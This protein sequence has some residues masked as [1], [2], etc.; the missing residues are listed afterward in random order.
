MGDVFALRDHC[1]ISSSTE[2]DSFVG[3][4]SDGSNLSI[5]FPLGYT[6]PARESTLRRDILNLILC[7][8]KFSGAYEATMGFQHIR[9]HDTVDFPIQAYMNILSVYRN[10]TSNLY[11]ER[12]VRYQRGKTTGKVNWS[13]TIKNET[14]IWSNGSPFYLTHVTRQNYSNNET[15]IGLILEY[16]VYESYTKIGFLFPGAEPPK[17][18]LAFDKVLFS[19]TIIQKKEQVRED[20]II[21]LFDDVLAIIN[22]LG[23]NQGSPQ[24]YFGTERFEYV[25]EKMIDFTFGEDNKESYFPHT[26]WLLDGNS[27]KNSALE[28][29]T[30]MLVGHNVFVLDAKYYRY[31]QTYNAQHLPQS[32]SI[33]KQITY[34]EYIASTADFRQRFGDRAA[35]YNA[36]LMPY[37]MF[38]NYFP[39]EGDLKTYRHIGEAV[40][41]WRPERKNEYEHVQGIL[42]DV[43]SLM[44]NYVRHNELEMAKLANLIEN[45]TKAALA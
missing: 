26:S 44:H 17:P 29:D 16:C 28:P 7:L 6:I 4:C 13:R 35:V 41:D 14:P 27:R 30:I 21:A 20:R 38:S 23:D 1:F 24:F 39:F 2:G 40:C 34:G 33:N 19:S 32:S 42:I 22:Y 3:I 25:W 45:S 5:F 31:G 36:F 9:N 37:N 10:S 43:R 12:E 11:T 18:R 8:S 15:M